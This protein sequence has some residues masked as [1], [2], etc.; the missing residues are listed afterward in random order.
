MPWICVGRTERERARA[1]VKGVQGT[2]VIN[3][4]YH[5]SASGRM[6]CFPQ[7]QQWHRQVTG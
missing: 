4:I 1:S 6:R 2:C 5:A 7:Q 3:S